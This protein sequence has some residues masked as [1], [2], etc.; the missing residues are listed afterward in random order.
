M[1][2]FKLYSLNQT[3][4][5][6]QDNPSEEAA[7]TLKSVIVGYILTGFIVAGLV[8]GLLGVLSFTSVW[9]GPYVLARILFFLG[10]IPFGIS[11]YLLFRLFR[12]V[13]HTTDKVFQRPNRQNKS[14]NTS[15]IDVEVID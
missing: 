11:L 15:V 13:S 10:V 6:W 2:L 7:N 12:F 4:K 8:L 14:G 1:L 5:A 9:G 3:R